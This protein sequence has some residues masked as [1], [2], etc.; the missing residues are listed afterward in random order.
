MEVITEMADQQETTREWAKDVKQLGDKIVELS[1]LKAQE[2][3]DYLKDV[4]GIEPAAAAVAVAA[5]PAAEAAPVEEEKTAFD[6]VLKAIGDKKI[7]VIKVVRAATS[8]GLKEAKEL[9]EKAPTTVKEG[10]SK[11]DADAF[12]TELESHGAEV[13]IK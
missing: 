11:E 4:H 3:G 6:V 2:L 9:V 10:L 13:E 1:L 12:K 8:L 7:Q 5:G